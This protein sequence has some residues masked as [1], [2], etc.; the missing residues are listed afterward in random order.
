M[1]GVPTPEDALERVTRKQFVE[2]AAWK[3]L[4]W[5]QSDKLDFY[6]A[7]MLSVLSGRAPRDCLF[8]ADTEPAKP[9]KLTGQEMAHLFKAA[10]GIK[11]E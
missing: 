1:L 8:D 7:Q 6:L 2:F 10:W 3:A 11:D 5:K 4:Q 9:M